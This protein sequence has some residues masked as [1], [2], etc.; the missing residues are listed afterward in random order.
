MKG[1]LLISKLK[2]KIITSDK[3]QG[4]HNNALHVSMCPCHSYHHKPTNTHRL[5]GFHAQGTQGNP[6]VI[7]THII[8]LRRSDK[9]AAPF[10]FA[11]TVMT[12]NLYEL[13]FLQPTVE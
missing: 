6:A 11:K 10:T 5:Y 3:G 8:Y 9:P 7:S 1:K 13:I 4:Q 12:L 2:T